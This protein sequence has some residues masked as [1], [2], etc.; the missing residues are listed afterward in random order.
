MYLPKLNVGYAGKAGMVGYNVGV[1]GTTFSQTVGAGATLKKDQ[2][3]VT[4]LGYANGSAAF[5][6]TKLLASVSVSQNAGNMSFLG[7]KGY[8]AANKK[9]A[10]G[11]EGYIQASQKVSDT[12]TANVGLGY[13]GDKIDAPAVAGV[14]KNKFDNKMAIFVNAPVTLAK[15]VSVTPE[16]DYYDQLNNT[17]GKDEKAKAYVIG[18]KCQINF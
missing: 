7:R 17:A 8:D 10:I 11:F 12:L 5:G 16:F 6:A 3:I 15:N 18:A 13:A 9:D 4:V 14:A 2:Q 1:V